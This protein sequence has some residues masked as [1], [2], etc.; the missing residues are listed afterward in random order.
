MTTPLD[1]AVREGCW[2]GESCGY[3]NCIENPTCH[4]RSAAIKACLRAALP[5][6]SPEWFEEWMLSYGYSDGP[7]FRV[8]AWGTLR[9]RMLGEAA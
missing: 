7:I 6:E 5:E 4:Q 8:E 3:P 1:A 9:A 2:A